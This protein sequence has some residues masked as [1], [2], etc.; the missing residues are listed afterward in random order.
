[1]TRCYHD[2]YE[3]LEKT[4]LLQRLRHHGQMDHPRS[5]SQ[6]GADSEFNPGQK[7]C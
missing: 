3:E 1:M 6:Q 5:Q 4:E 2:S 7:D